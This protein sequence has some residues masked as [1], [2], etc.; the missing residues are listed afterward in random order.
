[1][2]DKIIPIYIDDAVNIK[3]PGSNVINKTDVL[4]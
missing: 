2:K 3:D 1:M 4:Y